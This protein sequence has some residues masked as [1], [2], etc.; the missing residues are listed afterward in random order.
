MKNWKLTRPAP[1]LVT[2]ACLLCISIAQ[3]KKP[4]NPGGGGGGGGDAASYELTD[5]LGFP[6]LDLPG[7][8][9]Q[10]YGRFITNRTKMGMS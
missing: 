8:D 7:P 10:S 6:L 2:A 4:G 3:A 5:L 1:A 9:Y